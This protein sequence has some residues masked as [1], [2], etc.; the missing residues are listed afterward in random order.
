MWRWR[1]GEGMELV[2]VNVTRVD[3]RVDRNGNGEVCGRCGI[4]GSAWRG[5]KM[6]EVI[7]TN[8]SK[9]ILTVGIRW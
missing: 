8:L 6:R 4:D 3:E 5:R 2:H 7:D 1:E 9:G